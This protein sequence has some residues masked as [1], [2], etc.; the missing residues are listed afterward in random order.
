M[1][2]EGSHKRKIGRNNQLAK[3]RKQLAK[4]LDVTEIFADLRPEL[5]KELASAA[6][7][8]EFRRVEN[9]RQLEQR[10]QVLTGY[11]FDEAVMVKGTV[12]DRNGERVVELS[13]FDAMCKAVNLFLQAMNMQNKMWGIYDVPQAAPQSESPVRSVTA[14]M[15]SEL[16]R[17]A[18]Q[19]LALPAVVIDE[20]RP[21]NN[22][23]PASDP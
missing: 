23:T 14:S 11:I 4:Q 12:P 3:I 16:R 21:A 22:G 15:V 18:K 7:Y 20:P 13:H 10:K 5:Q 19:N 6:R 17:I 2:G 9:E 8:C 1:G